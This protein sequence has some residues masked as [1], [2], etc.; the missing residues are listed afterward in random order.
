MDVR[1]PKKQILGFPKAETQ[2]LGTRVPNLTTG[3][4][5]HHPCAPPRSRW[6]LQRFPQRADAAA[7]MQWLDLASRAAH[8]SAAGGKVVELEQVEHAVEPDFRLRAAFIEICYPAGLQRE[9][10]LVRS[11]RTAWKLQMAT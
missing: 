3:A 2:D 11:I 4:P 9:P 10:N 8:V 1:S 7:Y 5:T 6:T